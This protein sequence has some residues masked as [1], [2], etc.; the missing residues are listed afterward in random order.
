MTKL[1]CV[2]FF[3]LPLFGSG[4]LIRGIHSFYETIA[5]EK[6]V[7]NTKTEHFRGN[8]KQVTEIRRVTHF[9]EN[10]PVY[11]TVTTT[12]YQF[13]PDG[14]L[15]VF[16]KGDSL[17]KLEDSRA[18]YEVYDFDPKT[19]KLTKVTVY[20]GQIQYS[21]IITRYI[22]TRGFVASERFQALF[23]E[24]AELFHYTSRYE[25][26]SAHTQVSVRYQYDMASDRYER[27]ENKKYIFRLNGHGQL[28]S[29]TLTEKGFSSARNISRHPKWQLPVQVSYIERCATQNSCLNLHQSIEYDNKGNILAESLSDFTIRNALWSY[30]YCNRFSYNDK[31]DLA[32]KKNC[33]VAKTRQ[34]H[35]P[36][37]T[38]NNNAS[39]EPINDNYTVYEYKYDEKGNW[40]ERKE[41]L[42]NKQKERVMVAVTERVLAYYTNGE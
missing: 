15:M 1:Y 36:G 10:E 21:H 34:I 25:Y 27:Q 11:D 23:H 6:L 40:T 20:N 19:R 33:M 22:N 30:A 39:F 17:A 41:F 12:R 24:N 16:S 9:Q 37:I 32:E 38:N 7:R 18:L 28:I 3:C 35:L 14:L 4:Q 29:E 42:V 2:V 5:A 8:P 26:N 13:T 31:N